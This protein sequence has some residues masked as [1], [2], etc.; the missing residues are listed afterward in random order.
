M[1]YTYFL[2][3]KNGVEK[4]DSERQKM[5]SIYKKINSLNSN[6]NYGGTYYGH[7]YKR[8]LGYAEFSIYDLINNKID[9]SYEINKQGD[10]F[11]QS[12]NQ[13]ITD[14]VTMDGSLSKNEKKDRINELTSITDDLSKLITNSF[15]LRKA[16]EFQYRY[17]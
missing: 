15:Y 9:K 6:I 3:S 5:I 10:L 8:I 11:I 14:E 2:K 13:Y 7:Q 4:Y 16:Q 1:V 17:Y 12:L